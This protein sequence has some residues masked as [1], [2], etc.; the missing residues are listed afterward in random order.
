MISLDAGR[1]FETF[2]RES[3]QPRSP[4]S[5]SRVQPRGWVRR[6]YGL[7][8]DNV[9]AAQVVCAD[10]QVRTASADTNPDLYWALR[11]G[12]GNF[13][14]VTSLTFRL[15]PLDPTVAFAGV[16]YPV[17]DA[18]RVWRAF[19]DKP[20]RRSSPLRRSAYRCGPSAGSRLRW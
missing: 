16:F 1:S 18:A 19:R 9:V 2:Q 15:H 7:S 5:A 3:L 8:S 6:K 4:V 11:G 12:G 13:G 10:G 17:A 20:R 14:I